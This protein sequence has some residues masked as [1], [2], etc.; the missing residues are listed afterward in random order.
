MNHDKQYAHRN[1]EYEIN[2]LALWNVTKL[3]HM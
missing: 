2:A 1:I 3:F